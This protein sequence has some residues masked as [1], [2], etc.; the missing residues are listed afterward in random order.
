[1][2]PIRIFNVSEARHD[3]T[4]ILL[5][6]GASIG[7]PLLMFLYVLDEDVHFTEGTR[8]SL[9]VP[10]EVLGKFLV[11]MCKVFDI[12]PGSVSFSSF[13]FFLDRCVR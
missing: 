2:P 7:G 3:I 11:A 9:L 5:G 1:M 10:G 8:D 13:D 4:T 6:S 12:C